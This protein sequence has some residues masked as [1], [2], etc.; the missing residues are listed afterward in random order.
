M[1]FS[2]KCFL[3]FFVFVFLLLGCASDKSQ[4]RS[5]NIPPSVAEKPTSDAPGIDSVEANTTAASV[6]SAETGSE[7]PI[8]IKNLPTKNGY[9]YAIKTK[10]PGLVKSPYAQDKIL[11]DVSTLKSDSP[12]RCPHTGK[13]FIVP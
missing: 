5:A 13:I 2:F 11:V 1:N 7:Q 3:S 4:S 6:P 9:P 8:P 10:W 12:A